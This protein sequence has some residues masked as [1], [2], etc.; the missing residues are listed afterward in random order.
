MY[1][2]VSA[3]L[4]FMAVSGWLGRNNLARLNVEVQLPQEIYDG[5]ETL[6]T[7]RL[8]NRQR[9]FPACLLGLDYHGGKAWCPLLPRRSSVRLSLAVTFHGRGLQPLPAVRVRSTFPINFFVRSV[10][11]PVAGDVLVFPRPIPVDKTAA[12]AAG[13]GQGEL[14]A[15]KGYEGDLT[16]IDD[17][18]GGRTPE[19]DP[20]EDI[21][22][23]G[24]AQGQAV[25]FPCRAAVGHRPAPVA[26]VR[27][28]GTS[29]GGLLAD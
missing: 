17:Y 7:V 2:L 14:A 16:R 22:T 25:V 3:L 11:L 23:P 5:V 10:A 20:L 8:Y 13:V 9:W 26:G 29:W 18:R 24:S 21:R 19:T 4:G 1:L 28:R 12:S 15:E 27:H 6:V